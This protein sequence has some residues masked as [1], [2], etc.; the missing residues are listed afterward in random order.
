[1]R[2]LSIDV[3]SDVVCPWCLIGV[4][5]LERALESF[6]DVRAD[7]RFHPF[8]LDPSTPDEGVDLRER[9]RA[10]YGVAPERM[11]ERVE[12]AARESGIPLDFTKVTRSVAT[13]RAHTLLRHAAAKGT[14]RALKKALLHAYFLE[15][16]D[17]GS[18]D[19]LV[20]I[21]SAHGFEADEARALLR[22]DAE[23]R[24]TRDEAAAVASQGI[25]GVPFFVFGERLAFSG[26][27][28]VDVMKSVIARA[29]DEQR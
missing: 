13:P 1:M 22:D 10:K 7:V 27:Q 18:I 3:V 14:Q 17:V 5:R 15:G 29:L 2:E 4:E 6:P 21:A 19:E 16:R 8:L 20:A 11:F 12:S 24:R 25:S 26:A 23:L 28:S 9:L